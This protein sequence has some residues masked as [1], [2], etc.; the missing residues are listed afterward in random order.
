[1]RHPDTLAGTL[2][3]AM[4]LQVA[5]QFGEKEWVPPGVTGQGQAKAFIQALRL[6]ERIFFQVGS[7]KRLF[8]GL[9]QIDQEAARPAA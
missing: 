5:Q 2:Q 8:V 7:H 9:F 4:R 3:I 6:Q 1:M